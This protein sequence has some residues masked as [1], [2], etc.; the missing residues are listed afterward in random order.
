[1]TTLDNKE[2]AIVP[3]D[4]A[5]LIL[6]CARTQLDIQTATRITELARH[7]LDWPYLI[8]IAYA[9]KLTPLV[10]WHLNALC[11]DAVAPAILEEMRDEFYSNIRHNLF[12][13]T[14][15]FDLL[16]LLEAHRIP[17][18]PFKGP[19]LAESVYG[20]L[21]FRESVDLDILVHSDDVLRAR[22]V[23]LSRGYQ[24]TFP[25]ADSDEETDLTKW[26]FAQEKLYLQS[27]CEQHFEDADGRIII[28]LHWGI[29]PTFF[30]AL[31]VD[32]L[33][34]EL[35]QVCLCGRDIE[36]LRQ[37][38]L[39]LILCTIGAKDCW[40]QLQ[41]VCDVAEVL[42]SHDQ[43][44]WEQ[45]LDRARRVGSERMLLLG[46]YLAHTLL[47]APL[48]RTI[49]WRLDADA[50]TRKLASQVLGWLF[51]ADGRMPAEPPNIGH[52][53]RSVLFH[54]RVRE[55]PWDKL[56]YC[57]QRAWTPNYRDWAFLRLPPGLAF[58]Y[59]ALRPIRLLYM[60]G[61]RAVRRLLGHGAA[62]ITA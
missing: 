45:V 53:A 22:D 48:P 35:Q 36:T 43:L 27:F 50:V 37:E 61:P 12:L 60:H 51:P 1:M 40:P 41:R 33:W 16:H 7:D 47:Q 3:C 52:D 14:E 19:V 10:Y 34:T 28:D 18:I 21:A 4:E 29:T 46:L 55:R 25:T 20:N 9:H 6:C 31:H 38:D 62:H 11:P 39:L 24:M 54:L 57:W 23:L 42:R 17:T 44:D 58:L 56:Q 26:T 5:E 32:G 49:T 2:P 30:S 8:R 59:Y 13:A 15:L